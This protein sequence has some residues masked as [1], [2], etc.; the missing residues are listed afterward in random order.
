MQVPLRIV[1]KGVREPAKIRSI[2]EKAASG[3]EK[4]H[5]RVTSCRVAVTNPDSRHAQ[6][7]LYDVHV[8]LRVPGH[9]DIAISQRAGDDPECEH[10]RVALRRAFAQARRRLQDLARQMRGDVKIHEDPKTPGRVV[11]LFARSGY[12]IIEAADGQEF[13]FH[14][15]SVL[16]G[17]FKNLRVGATVRFVESEGDKGPQASTVTPARATRL[18]QR[19]RQI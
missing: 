2:I 14:R 18:L 8:V 12:G 19:P 13:Y 3:L 1:L 6:G 11:K 4:F 9:K 15:N 16:N 17:G 7:G 10:V 5:G